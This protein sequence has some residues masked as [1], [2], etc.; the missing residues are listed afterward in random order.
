MD[1]GLGLGH[2]VWGETGT[3]W[4]AVGI[5]A[6]GGLLLGKTIGGAVDGCSHGDIPGLEELLLGH[7]SE[8]VVLFIL[9]E[10]WLAV[11]GRV[12]GDIEGSAW[13]GG[14]WDRARGRADA[15]C[16][17]PGEERS[18]IV[19]ACGSHCFG[20]IGDRKW[21]DNGLREITGQKSSWKEDRAGPEMSSEDWGLKEEKDR[22][23]SDV[24]AVS[25]GRWLGREEMKRKRKMDL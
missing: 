5:H 8:L 19:G 24:G 18:T 17:E 20:G 13:G 11:G 22:L 3:E 4:D 21:I 7:V 2:H 14:V 16:A 15:A 10:S 25:G 6:S 9:C 23:S 1:L 12:T